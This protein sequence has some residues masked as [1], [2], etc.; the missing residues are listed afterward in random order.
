MSEDDYG[1]KNGGTGPD[2]ET[3]LEE[4]EE[5]LEDALELDTQSQIFLEMHSKISTSCASQSK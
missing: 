1:S 4:S 3:D 5:A 2:D